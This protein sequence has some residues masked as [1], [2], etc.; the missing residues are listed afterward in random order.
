MKKQDVIKNFS[1]MVGGLLEQGYAFNS[2]MMS[3]SQGEVIKVGLQK[4]NDGVALSIFLQ[5]IKR[6]DDAF[7]YFEDSLVL[8]AETFNVSDWEAEE[9]TYWYSKERSY[10]NIS[11]IVFYNVCAKRHYGHDY[12]NDW[13]VFSERDAAIAMDKQINRRDVRRNMRTEEKE[14]TSKEAKEL[15]VK[16]LRK[17]PGYKRAKAEDVDLIRKV[18]YKDKYVDYVIELNKRVSKGAMVKVLVNR[19]RI[20]NKLEVA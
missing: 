10:K 15:A 2:K 3:G 13:F 19:N 18:C 4:G 6:K 5:D 1:E 12:E 11:E 8:Y 20:Y 16:I 9:S 17:V 7:W 14:F